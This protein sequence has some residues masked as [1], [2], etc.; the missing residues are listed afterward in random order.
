MKRSFDIIISFFGL[1]CLLPLFS[2]VAFILLVDDFGPV[3]YKQQRVGLH[4][5][6]FGMYKFRSMKT[7]A[8]KVGPYYTADNDPRVTRFGKWLRRS[9]IDELPQL[10]NVILGHMSLVGPR[11]NV[12]Q[13]QDLYLASS[14]HKRNTVRPGITGL[15]Q[16]TKRSSAINDERE[17]LDLE[18]VDKNNFMLDL[19]IILMTVKQV[20]LKGGN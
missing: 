6:L 19:E 2:I 14:W 18:Y 9:S 16:A 1:L 8:D 7:N 20:V 5:R 15:A 4:G 13:Q 11:P 12:P 10:L 3:F 17:L